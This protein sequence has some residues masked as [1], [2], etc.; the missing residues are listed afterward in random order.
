M[1]AAD[2]PRASAAAAREQ[3]GTSVLPALL[4]DRERLLAA[5]LVG[6]AATLLLEIRFEHR[7]ALGETA[8]AWIPLIYTGLCAALGGL[9]VLGWS[10]GGRRILPWL[11]SPGLVLG[12]LGLFFHSGGHP[13]RAL[14][15][16]LSAWGLK[17]GEAGPFEHGHPPA[18]APLAV[19]G[20]A[21]MAL[22]LLPGRRE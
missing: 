4:A 6:G 1:S 5:L 19:A 20:L 9:C 15:Q 10:R 14:S 22:L 11:F 8:R 12:P 3:E 16:V 7:E 18:L 17:P 13:L 2:G 21:A